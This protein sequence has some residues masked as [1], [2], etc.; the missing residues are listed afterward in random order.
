M[1][2]GIFRRSFRSYVFLLDCSFLR[3]FG[4]LFVRSFVCAYVCRY[5]VI[6]FAGSFVLAYYLVAQSFCRSL[7]LSHTRY[8]FLLR[9][10]PLAVDIII[11]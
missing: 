6:V 4:R 10:C 7:A 1:V 5:V 2:R 9:L 8:V 11:S 3:H